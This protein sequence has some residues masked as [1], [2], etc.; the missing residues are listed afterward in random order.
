MADKSFDWQIGE[1]RHSSSS[2]SAPLTVDARRRQ[3]VWH[4]KEMARVPTLQAAGAESSLSLRFVA[5]HIG[6]SR[7]SI[8]REIGKALLPLKRGGRNL[9]P[10]FRVDAYAAGKA[11]GPIAAVRSSP[12]EDSRP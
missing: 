4:A 9:W 5:A 12:A 1:S 10:L 6:E 3:L 8:Q 2:K 11:L 7:T